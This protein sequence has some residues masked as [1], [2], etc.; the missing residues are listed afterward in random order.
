MFFCISTEDLTQSNNKT[1]LRVSNASNCFHRNVWL[2]FFNFVNFGD[3]DIMNIVVKSSF[4][5]RQHKLGGKFSV[6]K[7]VKKL[8]YFFSHATLAGVN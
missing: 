4:H 2:C 1:S 3:S 8:K 6:L 7:L 5:R